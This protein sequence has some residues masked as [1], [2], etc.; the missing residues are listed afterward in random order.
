MNKK[1]AIREY[2]EGRKT[3]PRDFFAIRCTAGIGRVWVGSS[4]NLDAAKNG[5]WAG[6]KMGANHEKLLQ[7]EWNAHGEESFSYEVLETLDDDVHPMEVAGFAEV[8]AGGVGY[9]V[10]R[11]Q[12]LVGGQS[13]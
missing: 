12:A 6:L 13:F 7:A 5:Y 11:C 10:R 3:P 1:E 2:K 9:E 4:P 8:E